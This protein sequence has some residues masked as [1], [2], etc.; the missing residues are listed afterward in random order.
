MSTPRPTAAYPTGPGEA[1]ADAGPSRPPDRKAD[2]V[3]RMLDTPHPPFPPDLAEHAMA[4]GRR[5]LRRR[6]ARHVAGWLLLAAAL[7][8]A[9]VALGLSGYDAGPPG[10]VAPLVGT[11]G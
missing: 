2:E 8:A 3:R 11:T 10:G 9:A 1:G 5:L 6:R 7:L 4:R